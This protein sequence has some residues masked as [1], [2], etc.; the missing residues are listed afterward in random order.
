MT[1]KTSVDQKPLSEQAKKQERHN[2][3]PPLF[4]TVPDL[5]DY[6]IRVFNGQVNV[7]IAAWIYIM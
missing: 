4:D 5:M 7:E 6:G 2:E 1:N 3:V